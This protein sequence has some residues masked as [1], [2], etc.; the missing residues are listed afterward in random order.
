MMLPA[1]LLALAAPTA[2]AAPSPECGAPV[3]LAEPW[4]SWRQSG[5]AR[6]GALRDGAPALILGKPVVADLAPV[7]YVQFIAPPAKG[8]GM[9]FGGIFTLPVKNRARIG[10][11]LSSGAWV[12]VLDGTTPVASGDHGHGEPCSGIRKIVW[13]DLAPGRYLVQ[14]AGAADRSIRVMAADAAAN[15]PHH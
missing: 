5:T 4:T 2:A 10:I 11:A 13:F 7:D 14:I 8:G 3:L 9:G 12:D 15:Q 1:A 6:A